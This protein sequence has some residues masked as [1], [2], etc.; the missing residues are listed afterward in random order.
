[1][2]YSYLPFE[3]IPF[4]KDHFNTDQLFVPEKVFAKKKND[5]TARQEYNDRYTTHPNVAKR[6]EAL[7]KEIAAYSDWGTVLN[8]PERSFEEVRS[9]CRFE[10]LLNQVYENKATDALYSIYVLEK[11]YPDSRFLDLCK[12]QIW[13]ELMK[14]M[15]NTLDYNPLAAFRTLQMSDYSSYEGEIS[16]LDQFLSGLPEEGKVALG[17]RFI[18]DIYRKDT[19]DA[20]IGRMWQ[21]AIEMAAAHSEFD[22]DRFSKSNFRE[23]IAK[24]EEARIA[25]EADT[26]AAST[27]RWDKYETIKNQRAGLTIDSGIDSSKFYLYGIADLLNDS[28][29]NKQFEGYRQ[30]QKEKE[31]EE[32][33]QFALTDEE[34]YD[35]EQVEYE[36][37]LHL[38]LD[39]V[40]FVNPLVTEYRG[41][42]RIDFPKSDKL[43]QTLI[44][45]VRAISSDLGV[46]VNYLDRTQLESMTTQQYNDMALVMRTIAKGIE[47]SEPDVFLIDLERLDSLKLVYGSSKVM[48]M[49]LEHA[50]NNH[51]TPGLA[52]AY[53]VLLPLGAIYFPIAL[54]TAHTTQ[55]NVY[56]MDLEKGTLLVNEDFYSQDPASRKMI[57][58]RLHSVFNQLKEPATNDPN[59]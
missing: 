19:T 44:E 42:D 33:D 32:E 17:L 4:R 40:L 1:L 59:D 22:P 28:L 7:E 24:L 11:D 52:V 49:T 3:E 15:S 6:I 31:R 13:L 38:S 43:E 20:L 48:M 53:T 39:T 21:K 36:D 54:L 10:S 12:A 18:H 58:A 37:R 16:V 27:Q 8:Y 50:Y 9:I 5:I 45:S 57:E 46:T 29:F 2:I 56:V 41:F 26:T 14:D 23:A 30:Q 25:A 55:M 34:I 47:T 51:I 35:I